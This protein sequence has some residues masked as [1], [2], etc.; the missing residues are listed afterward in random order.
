MTTRT[1]AHRGSP[2]SI[3]TITD[4]WGPTTPQELAAD[5]AD[6]VVEHFHELVK[7]AGG[8]GYWSPSTSELTVIVRGQDTDEGSKWDELYPLKKGATYDDLREQAQDEVWA[9][10]CGEKSPMTRRVKK[11][12]KKYPNLE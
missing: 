4:G 3:H 10:F 11:L 7:K 9:A 12:L 8:S 2:W 6:L 5:L 1:V